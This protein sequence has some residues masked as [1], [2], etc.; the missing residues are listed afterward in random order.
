VL[1]SWRARGVTGDPAKARDFY[2]RAKA[3][4]IDDAEERLKR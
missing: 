2:Q 4:G 1:E 3:G